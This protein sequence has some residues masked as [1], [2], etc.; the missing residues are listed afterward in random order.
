VHVAATLRICPGLH[1][2]DEGAVRD[3]EQ[4]TDGQT[5]LGDYMYRLLSA[6]RKQMRQKI[7]ERVGVL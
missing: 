6:F 4:G 5:K 2:E 7:I 3:K 1:L